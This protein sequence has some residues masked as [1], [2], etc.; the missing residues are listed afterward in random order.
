MKKSL[1]DSIID[2]LKSLTEKNGVNQMKIII[3][4]I[5]DKYS[6]DFSLVYSL[7]S[8]EFRREFPNKYSNT[9]AN[10]Q[11]ILQEWKDTTNETL[12][13]LE[14]A[15]KYNVSA[16]SLMRFIVNQISPNKE[17]A[18][19]WL[20]N[21]NDCD[22][23]RLAYEIMEINLYDMMDGIFTQQMRLNV[24]L[25]FELEIRDYLQ[26]NKISFLCEQQLRDRNY[27]VTPDFC[28]NLPL[29]LVRSNNKTDDSND[30]NIR[31]FRTNQ[32][33]QIKQQ[34]IDDD[35]QI[36]LITW[37]ECK[38]MFASIECHID[39]YERQ[40]QSYINRFGNGIVLYKHGLID[41]GIPTEFTRNLVIIQQMPAFVPEI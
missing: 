15:Q 24:G 11:Q 9:K 4:A 40:Y 1:F 5:C 12:S 20:K 38:A 21:P 17:I 19:Q 31:L 41:D 13:I 10:M 28:L 7:V 14:L 39:Y 6:L 35:K 3:D 26:K 22:N 36:I 37:I 29:I 27:D 23:G 32:L 34:S 18:K 25:S 8:Y 30:N 33:D 2:D 16:Y